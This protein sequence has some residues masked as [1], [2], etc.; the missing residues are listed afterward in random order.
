[1]VDGDDD[2]LSQSQKFVP[3]KDKNLSS[4]KVNSRKSL[5]P[6]GNLFIYLLLHG[7]NQPGKGSKNARQLLF[8]SIKMRQKSTT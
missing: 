6:H 2:S 4:T 7:R 3:A 1:M 5:V 8:K